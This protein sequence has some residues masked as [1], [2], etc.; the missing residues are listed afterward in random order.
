R[1]G[2]RLQ[3]FAGLLGEIWVLLGEVQISGDDVELGLQVVHDG[4][5]DLRHLLLPSLQFVAQPRDEITCRRHLALE[6]NGSSLANGDEHGWYPGVPAFGAIDLGPETRPV[7]SPEQLGRRAVGLT[8]GGQF[9]YILHA[10]ELCRPEPYDAARGFAL[11][12]RAE[13]RVRVDD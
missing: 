8:L 1:H 2:D 12:H 11:E 10:E 9:G 5:D 6:L 13:E 4:G 3:G 7:Q